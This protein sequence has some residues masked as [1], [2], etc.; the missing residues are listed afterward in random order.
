MNHHDQLRMAGR[1]EC[2]ETHDFIERVYE[3]L[4]G[5]VFDGSSFR[6]RR[7]RSSVWDWRHCDVYEDTSEVK[8]GLLRGLWHIPKLSRNFFFAECFAKD[9][10][11]ITFE[12]DGCVVKAK[13]LQWKLGAHESKGLF[14]LCMKPVSI[15][16]ANVSSSLECLGTPLRTSGTFG[17]G[18]LDT[19]V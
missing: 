1:L 10:G 13:G 18:T 5:C 3:E 4:V 19:A 8:Q 9:V 14:R 11:T 15:D 6:N 7:C 17:L 16:E 12:S 2:D